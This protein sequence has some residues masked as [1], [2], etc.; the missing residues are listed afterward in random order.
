MHSVEIIELQFPN[1][2]YA[3]LCILQ[4]FSNM[5]H[6]LSLKNGYLQFSFWVSIILVKIYLHNHKSGQKF[7]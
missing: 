2:R 1:E 6:E 7:L 5:V 4:L 3:L